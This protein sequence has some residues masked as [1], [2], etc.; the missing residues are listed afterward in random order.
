MD[1]FKAELDKLS[2]GMENRNGC[3]G[4]PRIAVFRRQGQE[5]THAHHR[6]GRGGVERLKLRAGAS[7]PIT[8]MQ[9]MH[10]GIDFIAD[11]GTPI[12]AAAGGMVTCAEYHPQYGN[13][14][15]IDHGNDFITRYAPTPPNSIVRWEMWSNAGRKIAEVGATGR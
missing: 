2:R 7:T 9:A 8:G 15:E 14:V 3:H 4:H 12:F 11:I 5:Q 13:M 6:S 1:E 10:E